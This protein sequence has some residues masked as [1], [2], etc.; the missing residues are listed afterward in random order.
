MPSLPFL[1]IQVHVPIPEQ[2]LLKGQGEVLQQLIL[3][4]LEPA[5]FSS[6]FMRTNQTTLPLHNNNVYYS[7][8]INKHTLP[9][10]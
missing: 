7:E 3:A 4:G 10:Q 6:A 9:S 8:R 5:A 2:Q 1:I